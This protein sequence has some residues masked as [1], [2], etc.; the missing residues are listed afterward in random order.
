MINPRLRKNWNVFA[1]SLERSTRP[2]N[3]LFSAVQL[4]AMLPVSVRLLTGG[5]QS[6]AKIMLSH[7]CANLGRGRNIN[8]PNPRR[9]SARRAHRAFHGSAFATTTPC[10]ACLAARWRLLD[11]GEVGATVRG[12][13]LDSVAT[14]AGIGRSIDERY[15]ARTQPRSWVT[16]SD[17]S[18]QMPSLLT[19]CNSVPGR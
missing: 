16:G 4:I 15:C 19:I 14:C 9:R 5:V 1:K 7:R 13:V 12:S 11:F 10:T 3:R 17:T 2:H 18:D 6:I 8:S